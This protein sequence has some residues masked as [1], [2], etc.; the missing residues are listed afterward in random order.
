MNI[1]TPISVSALMELVH[2]T[3]WMRSAIPEFSRLIGPLRTLLEL[4]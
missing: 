2:G 4:N 3:N 1:Q